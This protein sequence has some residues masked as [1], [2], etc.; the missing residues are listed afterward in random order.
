MVYC[1]VQTTLS[2]L[3][4]SIYS[5]SDLEAGLIYLPFGFGCVLGT[6]A[7]NKQDE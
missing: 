6:L 7:S 5:L 1:S 4:I 2:S 3:F